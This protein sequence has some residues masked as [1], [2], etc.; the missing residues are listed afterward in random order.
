MSI[1]SVVKH[2]SVIAPDLIV[3]E[4][5]KETASAEEAAEVHGVYVGQIVKTLALIIENPV[6][7]MIA[8]DMKLD[9]KKYKS[10]FNKKAKM[11]NHEETLKIT[12]HPVGGVCPF[13]LPEKLKI[14]ADISLNDYEKVIPAAGSRNSSV[15]VDR[16][17]L[18]DLLDAKII[19]VSVKK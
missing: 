6:L 3:M 7:V 16:A 11:L 13:G 9:N 8:G 2:L 4:H 1:K 19:D 5:E 15:I 17:R 14:Y 12:S 10:T 18:I